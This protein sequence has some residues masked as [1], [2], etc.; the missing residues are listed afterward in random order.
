MERVWFRN[1]NRIAG[2]IGEVGHL[3]VSWSRVELNKSKTDPKAFG[4]LHW[5]TSSKWQGLIIGQGSAVHVDAEHGL[6]NPRA[7][8]PV[9]EYGEEWNV[10]EELASRPIGENEAV[11][12]DPVI[13]QA[14]R[15]VFGQEHVVFITGLPEFTTGV[16]KSIVRRLN[17][18]QNDFPE[19]CVY[20]DGSYSY[21]VLFGMAFRAGNVDTFESAKSNEV[22]LPSGR[23]AKNHSFPQHQK[24]IHL[25]GASI[26]ELNDQGKRIRYNC[27][28]ALWAAENFKRDIAFKTQKP[29]GQVDPDA[30][31]HVPEHGSNQ[32][33][34]GIDGDKINCDTCSL[35]LQCKFYR[36]GSV[37]TLPK[38]ETKDLAK[39]FGTRDA[40]TIVDALGALVGRQAQ[41]VERGMAEE[42][43][44]GVLDPEVSK[45]LNS[46]IDNG[47]KLAKIIDPSRAG[48]TKVQVNVGQGAA[49]ATQVQMVN[50]DQMVGQIVRE[51]TQRTG[52][53]AAQITQEMIMQ[54]LMLMGG[55]AQVV[56]GE[57]MP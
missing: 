1:P 27:K 19:C 18:F 11:C 2:E 37:C 42:E 21:N 46:T 41:R 23:R 6:E 40:D 55:G 4:N 20:I 39:M 48:G 54:Q 45:Q 15:P 26:P 29:S 12:S 22:I 17:E 14:W 16:G 47:I 28:S 10:L 57:V 38:T 43:V 34:A 32:I 44:L 3:Y 53:P 56:Q 24:W 33:G 30:L 50:P 35:A 51:I 52:I 36:L 13:D 7:V 25:L 49:S 31:V 5:G 9:W 8:Y